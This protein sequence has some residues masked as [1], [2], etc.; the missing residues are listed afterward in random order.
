M[1]KKGIIIGIERCEDCPHYNYKA[2]DWYCE[3]AKRSLIR[4]VKIPKWCPLEKGE[5]K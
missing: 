3:K 2:F 5:G 4:I 1:S